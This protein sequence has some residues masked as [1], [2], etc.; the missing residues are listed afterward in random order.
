MNHNQLQVL[1]LLTVLSFSIFVCK[2]HN[3]SGFDVEN[4]VMS[5]CTVIS[6]YF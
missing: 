1:F 5:M 3:Q 2:E 6:H 4:L